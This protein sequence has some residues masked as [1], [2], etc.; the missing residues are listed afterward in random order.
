MAR[1]S[2]NL[3]RSG[4]AT[5]ARLDKVRVNRFGNV[6]VDVRPDAA[7]SLWVIANGKGMSSSDRANPAWFGQPW[8]LRAGHAYSDLLIVWNDHAGHWVWCPVRNML[9]K[10]YVGALAYSNMHFKRLPTTRT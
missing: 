2:I 5:S 6:D 4:N 1:T 7:G 3:Y 10:D 9:L 8:C